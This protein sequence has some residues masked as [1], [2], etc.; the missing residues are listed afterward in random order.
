MGSVTSNT[1]RPREPATR[2][3]HPQSQTTSGSRRSRPRLNA[4][5]LERA[6]QWRLK[7]IW[8]PFPSMIH[9]T[10]PGKSWAGVLIP[11][12][13][14]LIEDLALEQMNKGYAGYFDYSGPDLEVLDE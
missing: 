14:D 6:H 11:K 12:E 9:T 3:S 13:L 10:F 7:I 5:E 1:G 4:A 2:L 8:A